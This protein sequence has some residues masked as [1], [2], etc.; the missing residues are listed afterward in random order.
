M[1][2]TDLTPIPELPVTALRD[3][4]TDYLHRVRRTG[5]PLLITRMGRPL[6]GL[7]GVAETRALWQVAQS[8][9][10]YA[11]WQ[12]MRRLDR[13]RDLRLALLREREAEQRRMYER[14]V[15]GR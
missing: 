2:E 10:G 6:A 15:L 8:R 4:L 7:V 12:A 11:E 9:E 1:A 5:R 3:H 14:E 13:D